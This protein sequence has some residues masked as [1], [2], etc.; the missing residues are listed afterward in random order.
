[1]AIGAAAGGAVT[2]AQINPYTDK[3]THYELPVRAEIAQGEHVE[4]A[5]DKAEVTLKGWNDEYAIKITPQIPTVAIGG[6]VDKVTS[7]LDID[8]SFKKPAKRSLFS[9][10]MEFKEGDVTA[11]IE[12][13]EGT[14]NE[15]DIDFTL[16]SKPDTNVFTY[17][18]EG[19]EEFDFFYQPE[20]TPEEIAEGAERPDNVVGSYAVYHKTKANHRVGST[21][22]ATG[23]AFHVYRPKAIDAN[24]AEVWAELNYDNGTLSVTV[25]QRFLDEAVYP[26]VVDPTFGYTSQ[27]ASSTFFARC[28]S[29]GTVISYRRGTLETPSEAGTIDSM[30]M[31]IA[32]LE[33]TP[34]TYSL[35]LSE[36][37]SGGS[38]SHGE[39][40]RHSD[41]TSSTGLNTISFS[42]ENFA[43]GVNYIP[44]VTGSGDSLCV[45]GQTRNAY[46]NYDN[47]TSLTNYSKTTGAGNYA[48]LASENPWTQSGASQNA[49][50]S[51]YATYTAAASAPIEDV[52][53]TGVYDE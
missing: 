19:A 42:S 37:D 51:I 6:P 45:V 46:F 44:N 31:Y 47:S 40:A 38:G 4:I 3:G 15:F 12:P 11:F 2:D 9:K 49:R 35:A 48:T 24:G 13:K 5:K 26:V 21:N 1:M 43:G 32:S 23:K 14:E 16:D 18:I 22:Y 34:F 41:S 52:G 20:L 27:G 28:L 39:I 25:P 17:K 53:N 8:N 33:T 50:H 10:K 30:S 7:K 29:S 36:V